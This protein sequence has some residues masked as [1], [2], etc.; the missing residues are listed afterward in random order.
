MNAKRLLALL[1]ALVMVLSLTACGGN[2]AEPEVEEEP[3]E[4]APAEESE[5]AAEPA[6]EGE[7]AAE[8]GEEPAEDAAEP[9]ADSDAPVAAADRLGMEYDDMSAQVYDDAFGEFLDYYE[10]AL[11]EEDISTRW[12]LMAVAEAKMLESGVML[13]LSTN[14][15]MYAISRVAPYTNSPALWGNDEYRYYQRVVTEELITTADR[16]AMK[17][18]WAEVRGTGEYMGW[19]K[20]YLEDNGYTIKDEYNLSYGDDPVTWDVLAT[21]LQ[22][23]SEKIVHTYDGLMEYD[24][25]NV[26]QPALAESYEVS[27]DGL[28]YTF[29]I[30][31]GVNWVDS[32]GREIAPVT[33]DDWVAGMQHMCDAMGGLEYLVQGIIKG[34]NEYITGE[35]TDFDEVGVKAV[36]DYTLEYTLE[37][38]TSYFMTMLSYSIFA[39]MCRSYYES[40][41]G[42]FGA[43]YDSSAADY[44][45]GKGPDSI[46]YCGPFLVT[47]W[48]ENNSIVYEA[49]ESYWNADAVNFKTMTWKFDSGDDAMKAYN[50]TMS[51]TID[52]CNLTPARLE[53]AKIDKLDGDSETVFDK[54]YYI[55]STDATSFMGFFNLARG[56]W[57]NFN[58]PT[59]MTSEQTEE[60]AARTFAAMNNVHFRR[61]VAF[62]L[63]RAGYNA[64][65]VGE[66]LKLNSLRNSY[67]PGNFVTLE[68][69]VTVEVNG[70]EMEFAAGTNYGEIVQAQ[71]DADGVE[72]TVY[73]PKADGGVGSSDGF[74][75]W[76]N[77]E[78]A[79]EELATAIEELAEDGV[80][81][82]EENPIHLDLPYPSN[83]EQYTNRAN[84]FKQSLEATLEGAV[85]L[86]LVAGSSFDDWYYAGYYPTYGY[87][88]NYDLCDVSGWG[89]DYGD[90]QTYLDTLLPEYAGYMIKALGIY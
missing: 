63:D 8:E 85:V 53:Q 37:Q 25:E 72:L 42:K 22:A 55:S 27:D 30:R 56:S 83:N 61:A 88:G 44:N 36:D 54:Y 11:E 16:D 86:D 68:D 73:D 51:G 32:Q 23:D 89:P 43:E 75:G 10:K 79:K 31:E 15:G 20:E 39:P 69:D 7:E 3:V 38:P 81:I 52:G 5:D 18:H 62:S 78:A 57:G 21:S 19:A 90:P 60:D 35:I 45:Y 49:N 67:V 40:Q 29:H 74:D 41:G 14:G 80:E 84:A 82:S 12:A 34:V 87:E 2:T 65:V 58:D 17:A 59:V 48:V 47:S 76:Y 26:L 28:T 70:A 33:A 66:D 64:Q 50:D 13:P 6:E 71:I 4:E 77:P 46:A 1:L 9:A 24:V